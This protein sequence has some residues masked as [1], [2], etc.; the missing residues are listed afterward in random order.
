MD[1]LVDILLLAFLAISAIAILKLRDLFAMAM[2]FG[3]FSLISAGLFTTMDAPD[4]A[5]TEAAVGAGIST[6]LI[7]ATLS[8]TARREKKQAGRSIL[9]PLA[10][11]WIT[12]AVLIYGTADLPAFGDPAAPAHN[13]LAPH[14]LQE[15]PREIDIP[16][17]VA[18]VLASY[19]GYDTLGEVVVVFAAVVGV[20]SLIGLRRRPPGLARNPAALSEHAVLKVIAKL[21]VP[22]IL[23]FALYVQ[24]HGEYSPG[25][26]FQAGV[27]FAAGIIL[28]ALVFGLD[29]ARGIIPPRVLS[30]L[31]AT[32]ALIYGGV[33]LATMLLGGNFLDYNMLSADPV[34]GQHLGI[35]LVEIGVGVTV[36]S[37]ML[38][39]YFSFAERGR[40]TVADEGEP[41]R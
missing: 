30:K 20:I 6:I 8:Q 12:G 4:V 38:L 19:R 14:F 29:A 31:P 41:D 28:Y 3:L 17:V 32:G 27:I 1:T 2:M 21:V 39:I 10:V 25:G 24:F 23:L 15:S 26:G 36:S 18:A 33:G 7:L 9:V 35:M 22:V 11:V 37:V 16:N 40:G 5:F 13:Y 34:A